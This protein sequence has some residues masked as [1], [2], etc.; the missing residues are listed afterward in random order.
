MQPTTNSES[1]DLLTPE[2]V[3]KALKVPMKTLS[4]WRSTNRVQGLQFVRIGNAVRYRPADVKSFI[5]ANL[6][7]TASQP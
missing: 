1:E 3:S 6:K 5:E 2:D 7:Q 4:N